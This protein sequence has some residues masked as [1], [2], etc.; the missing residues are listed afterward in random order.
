[1]SAVVSK[2]Y[3]VTCDCNCGDALSFDDARINQVIMH[4]ISA[5]L[6]AVP[7]PAISNIVVTV[8]DTD[9]T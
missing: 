3:L 2:A 1:M 6:Q 5:A 7:L 9:G 4:A 8:E